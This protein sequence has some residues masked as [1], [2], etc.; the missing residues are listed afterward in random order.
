M[1]TSVNYEKIK[2]RSAKEA[3][4]RAAL[5]L[6]PLQ[7]HNNPTLLLSE[8][9]NGQVFL[10][11]L[12]R[13][14]VDMFDED[15]DEKKFEIGPAK[16]LKRAQKKMSSKRR[17]IE[18]N[19]DFARSRKFGTVEQIKFM[20]DKFGQRGTTVLRHKEEELTVHVVDV[21]NTFFIP[22]PKKPGLRNLDV[23]ILV[24]FN[25][26]N[27]EE[28]YHIAEFQGILDAMQE[29]WTQSHDYLEDER[30]HWERVESLQ[31]ALEN[32]QED[33]EAFAG[34]IVEYQ[35]AVASLNAAKRAR[36]KTNVIA[37]RRSEAAELADYAYQTCVNGNAEKVAL[38]I[39]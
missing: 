37:F 3:F 17:G 27:G 12:G 23:K 5:G 36:E 32:S 20:I 6:K 38:T 26:K 9:F 21:D 13:M 7:P 11:K 10:K 33:T 8:A 39:Q 18:E 22:D 31:L 35:E 34:L 1:A 4:E 16:D 24:Q 15:P 19:T 30:L 28:T 14:L 29:A 2:R 25:L